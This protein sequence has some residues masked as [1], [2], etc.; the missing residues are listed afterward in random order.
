MKRAPCRQVH[1]GCNYW[2]QEHARDPSSFTDACGGVRLACADDDAQGQSLEVFWEYELDWQIPRG[3]LPPEQVEAA[4]TRL[5]AV[6]A[7][8]AA[9]NRLAHYRPYPKQAAFHEA[10]AKHRERLLMCA[11]RFGK[12]MC[13]AAEPDLRPVFAER[14]SAILG[15]H[16]DPGPGDV[17]RAVRQALVGLWTPPESIELRAGPLRNAPAFERVSKRAV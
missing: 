9:E 15:A 4:I 3:R 13:G 5:E 16:P 2:S 10:G 7:Q 8:R 11:N 14:V 12:T 1:C 6:K 17:D